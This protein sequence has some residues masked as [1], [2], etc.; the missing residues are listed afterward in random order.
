MGQIIIELEFDPRTGKKNIRIEYESEPD[1]TK[2][3][4]EARHREIV[5]KLLS[6]G[7]LE[8]DEL[9]RVIVERGEEKTVEEE[10]RTPES[11]H[12]EGEKEST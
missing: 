6:E 7:V 12:R 3:E 9:G 4:H 1:L 10:R 5:Q 8:P 2:A 11:R